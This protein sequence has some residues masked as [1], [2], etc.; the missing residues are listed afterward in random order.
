MLTAWKIRDGEGGRAAGAFQFERL[1]VKVTRWRVILAGVGVA[2][3]GL[4]LVATLPAEV[5][6]PDDRDA[7]GTVWDGQMALEGGF[8]A[9]WRTQPLASL[10]HG[11]LAERLQVTGPLTELNGQALVRPGR[12]LLRD[13]DGV[14]SARLINAVAPALPFACDADLRVTIAELALKGA[15]AG[16]GTVR[17]SPGDCTPAG[18]GTPSPLPA[19]S[20]TFSADAASTTLTLARAGSETAVASAR[21]TPAG[22]L[23]LT[24]EPGGIGLFPG[25]NTP[26]SL[27]TTL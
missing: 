25:V 7:V 16:A 15:P 9:G 26:V 20:G 23:S 22:Q 13:L 17:S 1:A 19:L 12:V 14:A 4:G 8:A 3:Y 21:V 18:G 2:A 6:A 5:V 27:E 11:S 10:A 24:V